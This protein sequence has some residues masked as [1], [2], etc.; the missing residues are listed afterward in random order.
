LFAIGENFSPYSQRS[1]FV[2]GRGDLG[3]AATDTF[4]FGAVKVAFDAV[5]VCALGEN[6]VFRLHI[7]N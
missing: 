2:I 3:D 6:I 7:L 5:C 1:Y 4:V